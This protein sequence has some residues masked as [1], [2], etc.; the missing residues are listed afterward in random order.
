MNP[1]TVNESDKL[2]CYMK[3]LALNHNKKHALHNGE[4]HYSW[5]ETQRMLAVDSDKIEASQT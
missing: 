5:T 4:S 1:G 3:S 2:I